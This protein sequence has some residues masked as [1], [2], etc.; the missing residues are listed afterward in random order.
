MKPW[1]NILLEYFQWI[2]P[3]CIQF[4]KTFL[5]RDSLI[6]TQSVKYPSLGLSE[7]FLIIKSKSRNLGIQFPVFLIRKGENI[8][9]MFPFS[10]NEGY[11]FVNNALWYFDSEQ[12]TIFN[13]D[14]LQQMSQPCF[15]FPFLHPH[16]WSK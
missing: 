13:L 5:K 14:P 3:K 6:C 4:N 8:I 12:M 7:K 9:I 16:P 1:N 15:I 2:H 11:Y 10:C